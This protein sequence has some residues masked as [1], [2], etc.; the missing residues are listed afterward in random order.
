[1]IDH[2]IERTIQIKREIAALE[3]ELHEC[4]D[5]LQAAVEIGDLDAA[6]SHNDVGFK[7]N[8]GRSNYN[9]PPAVVQL[10]QQLRHAQAESIASG[11]AELTRGPAF[12]T[13]RLPRG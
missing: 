10:H 5:A 9:Y 7:L 13:I 11:A 2:T 6:F 3:A 8:A 4:L 1:M 12:W